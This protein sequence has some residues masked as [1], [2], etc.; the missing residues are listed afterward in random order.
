MLNKCIFM[1]R[2]T[3]D[4]DYKE[5]DS[6]KLARF[7]IAVDRDF[8]KDNGQKVDFI[9]CTAWRGTADF[10]QKYFDKGDMI[11]VT[12]RL[13]IDEEKTDDGY[14]TY[15]NIA[16]E[17]AYFGGAKKK[18]D[19]APRP[20]KK[21]VNV[22]ADDQYSFDDTPSARFRELNGVDEKELPFD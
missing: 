4:V 10:I 16:V 6:Y 15:T 22:S 21:A 19:D 1:G 20:A 8:A 12:G 3:K 17:N 14:R 5:T 2:L 7:T 18:N 9:K 11:V 13:Q